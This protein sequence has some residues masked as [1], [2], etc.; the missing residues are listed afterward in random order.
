MTGRQGR[1]CNLLRKL[2]SKAFVIV[3]AGVVI[4]S[5]RK[6][7]KPAKVSGNSQQRMVPDILDCLFNI[8]ALDCDAHIQG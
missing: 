3:P 4:T 1:G 2:R 7:D 6:I 5:G 8:H